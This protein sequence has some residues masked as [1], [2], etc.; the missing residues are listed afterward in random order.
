MYREQ[1]ETKYKQGDVSDSP[2]LLPDTAHRFP[3]LGM[4]YLDA[5]TSFVYVSQQTTHGR[6][7][8]VCLIT[9]GRLTAI[10]ITMQKVEKGAHWRSRE[11]V[12][13]AHCFL[14]Q[15]MGDAVRIIQRVRAYVVFG[16]DHQSHGPRKPAPGVL[17]GPGS[18]GE[19]GMAFSG[20]LGMR[21]DSKMFEMKSFSR[22]GTR[23]RPP[24]KL[25]RIVFCHVGRGGQC[26]RG[27]AEAIDETRRDM[28][29]IL[30]LY[31]R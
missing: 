9:F 3:R 31:E 30:G 26:G 16:F 25:L 29:R 24:K 20:M 14:P 8:T 12:V 10:T 23:A 27:S 15:Q 22:Q 28:T 4:G 18:L 21:S 19:G 6:A 2:I 11:G 1:S 7:C 17:W 5:R 13:D